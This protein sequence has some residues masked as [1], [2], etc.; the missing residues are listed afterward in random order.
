MSTCLFCFVDYK[1]CILVSLYQSYQNIF[2]L[3]NHFCSGI[4][5]LREF[6]R[7]DY[8]SSK[9]MHIHQ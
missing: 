5:F 6:H 9:I 8:R 4:N 7:L 1:W 3:M 2:L